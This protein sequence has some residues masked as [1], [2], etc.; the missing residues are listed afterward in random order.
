MATA[1]DVIL[2]QLG[3]G[4]FL[5]DKFTADFSDEEYFKIPVEGSN[6]AAWILGH[7]AV[8]EDSMAATAAG[9]DKKIPDSTYELFKGGSKCV[10]DASKYP[11]RKEIDELFKTSRARTIEALNSSDASTWDGPPPEGYPK[12]V[13]PTMGA[14]WGMLGTHQ[15]WHIGQLTVCR[16]VLKKPQVLM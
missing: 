7:I 6:H 3:T 14:I 15:F 16:A 8:S 10:A 13:F 5:M 12:E 2:T 9:I 4:Q 1:I 11:S